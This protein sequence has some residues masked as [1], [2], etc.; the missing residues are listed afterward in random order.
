LSHEAI[1]TYSPPSSGALLV[2][3]QSATDQG[4]YV[5]GACVDP[6]SEMGCL[7]DQ[8]AG[9]DEVLVVPVEAGVGV[10]IFVDAAK[11]SESGPF[12]LQTTLEAATE[13]EPNDGRA[14]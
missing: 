6:A 1:F 14:E 13:V 8:P 2:T 11:P 4:V 7:D 3:L 5:R 10:T 12:T 9:K